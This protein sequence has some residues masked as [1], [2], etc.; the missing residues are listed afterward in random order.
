MSQPGL[1]SFAKIVSSV[2]SI[3]LHTNNLTNV[4][5]QTALE[6]IVKNFTVADF[7]TAIPNNIYNLLRL[8]ATHDEEFPNL[9]TVLKE[10][11]D[12]IHSNIN[13]NIVFNNGKT[14][15]KIAVGQSS[16]KNMRDLVYIGAIAV[17]N[18]M[19]GV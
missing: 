2:Y 17:S 1:Q 12:I 19:T 10:Q 16:W 5:K 7:N 15:M 9:F 11:T 3:I 13:F 4:Q 18:G 6:F 14:P 8:M